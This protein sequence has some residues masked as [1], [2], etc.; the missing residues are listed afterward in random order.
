[1]ARPR[2]AALL[3]ALLALA[4]LPGAARAAT[5]AVDDDGQDCADARYDSIQD[6]VDAAAAGDTVAICPGTY[7]EGTGAAGTSS[8]VV[9][10]SLSLR[11][12]GADQVTIRPARRDDNPGTIVEATNPAIRTP[13]G[14]VVAV[15]GSPAVPVTV[16]IS[17]VTVSGA[18][19]QVKA[20]VLFLDAQG[21]LV[22]SRVTNIVTSDLASAETVP[23]GFRNGDFGVGVAQVTAATTPPATNPVRTLRLES[24]RI[25]R[26]NKTG[27]LID[28]ATGDAL[29]V[30]ASGVPNRGELVSTSVVGR[31]QCTNAAQNG[32]C[33]NPLP[34]TSGRL[35]GQ[36]GVR[37]TGG[38]SVAVTSS[39]ISQ[40]NVN[41]DLSPVRSS[42][43]TPNATN[44][45]NLVLGAGLRLIGAA[46]SSVTR[47][48]I[49]DNAYGAINALADGTTANTTTPLSAENNWWGLRYTTPAGN[50]TP[51]TGP[52]IAPTSNPPIPE[53]PV[54]GAAVADGAGTT[55]DAVDFFPFR[56][57]FQGDPVNGQFTVAQAPLPVNDAAPTVGLAASTPKAARGATVTLTAT[58]A[59]DFGTAAVTFYDGTDVIGTAKGRTFTMAY[60]V[61]LD[62]PCAARSLTAVA[63]D[64]SGQTAVS[65]PVTLTVAQADNCQPPTQVI[66]VPGPTPPPV[67]ITVPTVPE[68]GPSIPGELPAIS[69]RGTAVTVAPAAPAG[70][71]EVAFFLGDR[72]VCVVSA[73]PY[74]CVVRP[75]G[76]E[77]GTQVIRVVVTD[78][79]GRVGQSAR[80]ITVPRF[81]ADELSLDADATTLRRG[82]G[83]VAGGEL[84]RP[85][86]VTAGQGC[87]AGRVTLVL[88]RNGASIA[89]EEVALRD[90][91]SYRRTFALPKRKRG[92]SYTLSARFGGNGVLAARSSQT[93]RFN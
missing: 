13:T 52:A 36:D 78:R 82:R 34:P 62:A 10:K 66:T 15:I 73:A 30:T 50:P 57:G 54:N 24:T 80:T 65:T 56:N 43:T 90:D 20:G 44:N 84:A 68:G 74:R 70:V 55:S 67:V 28:G 42:N 2:M 39:L 83:I 47:S 12:A 72:R 3:A 40:N 92:T 91:C 26:Y 5:L 6:A 59:D 14:D 23:G 46:S 58:P 60:R 75:T 71:A 64:S 32:N 35:F 18:G 27:V 29:P 51:N 41:G 11:G 17:G 22:R 77:V 1:M 93:R 16:D 85:S 53:N 25:D 45:A 88:K 87:G 49:V 7:V 79:A 63:S 86:G 89:N 37:V 38:G 48:N 9:R 33:S 21:S 19:V 4:V 8:L 31:N 61:P 69:T 81:T 76:A